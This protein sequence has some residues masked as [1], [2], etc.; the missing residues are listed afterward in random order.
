MEIKQLRNLSLTEDQK[1]VLAIW[2]KAFGYALKPEVTMTPSWIKGMNPYDIYAASVIRNMLV[3]LK[4]S[5]KELK[6][7]TENL[8][9]TPNERFAKLFKKVAI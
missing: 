9:G 8:S 6:K 5:E 7:I 4:F 3:K 2:K 1:G